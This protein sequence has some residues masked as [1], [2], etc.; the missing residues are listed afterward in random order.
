MVDANTSAHLLTLYTPNFRWSG[1]TLIPPH[2]RLSDFINDERTTA[3]VLNQATPAAWEDGALKELQPTAS[4]ALI[5]R[6]VLLITAK[7]EPPAPR[8][9]QMERVPKEPFP[10]IVYIPPYT[11]AGEIRFPRSA[12]WLHVVTVA[13]EEFFVVTKASIWHIQTRAKLE[14]DLALVLVNRQW[15]LGLEPRR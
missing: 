15:L 9:S 8:A 12:D 13:T 2:R 14:T 4:I 3:L 6:N 11:L 1:E 10:V 5:K 7:A